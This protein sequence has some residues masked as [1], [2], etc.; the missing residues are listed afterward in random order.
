MK[1][2]GADNR[3]DSDVAKR[4]ADAALRLFSSRGFDRTS[5][6]ELC[7]GA[8]VSKGAFYYYF[9]S[10]DEVLYEIYAGRLKLELELLQSILASDLPTAGKL[11]RLA[12]DVVVSSV[13]NRDL[14]LIY[15]RS[16]HQLRPET[17]ELVQEERRRYTRLLNELITVAQDEKVIRSDM[18]TDTIAGYYLGA[19]QHL[20]HWYRKSESQQTEQLAAG[21]A[22]MFMKG[23]QPG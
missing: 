12:H 8:G 16:Q 23:I 3:S 17:R 1:A 6:Q 7:E 20:V 11:E 13:E 19:V 22:D 21:W 10:K 18:S 2:P 9:G 15:W 4:L 14:V 5:V